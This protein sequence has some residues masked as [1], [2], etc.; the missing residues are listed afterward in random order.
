MGNDPALTISGIHYM[1]QIL[2]VDEI[3]GVS[4]KCKFLLM[5]SLSTGFVALQFSGGIHG[6]HM[7]VLVKLSRPWADL[8]GG[9]G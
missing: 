2:A 8:L 9:G 4:I 1:K 7:I 5:P 6:G 3:D